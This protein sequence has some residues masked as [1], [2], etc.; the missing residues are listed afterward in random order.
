MTSPKVH[1]LDNGCLHVDE[2]FITWNHG[3]GMEIRFPVYSVYI[4]PP[5]AKS[6]WNSG[7]NKAWGEEHPP[8][9][10]PIQSENQTIEVQLAKCGAKSKDIDNRQQTSFSFRPLHLEQ[11]LHQ[12]KHGA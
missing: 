2:S 3:Q 5:D 10:K 11:A 8:F 6:C 12:R 1:F 7:F 4:D 9:E